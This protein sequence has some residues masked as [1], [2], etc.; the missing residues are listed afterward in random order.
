MIEMTSHSADQVGILTAQRTGMPLLE[1][2]R[3]RGRRG[4]NRI[5][6]D[7]NAGLGDAGAF[8]GKGS[9]QAGKQ[10]VRGGEAEAPTGS[11]RCGCDNLARHCGGW[12]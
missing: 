8:R 2:N 6:V 9:A 12:F 4:R 5:V 3:A 7:R 11:N 10:L 1:V